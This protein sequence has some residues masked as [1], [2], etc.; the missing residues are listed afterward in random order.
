MHIL[1]LLT[2]FYSSSRS[3]FEERVKLAQAATQ[4]HEY[5]RFNAKGTQLNERKPGE[6]KRILSGV[7]FGRFAKCRLYV[8]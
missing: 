3:S 2:A 8:F 6:V 4:E 5:V 7:F 1:T